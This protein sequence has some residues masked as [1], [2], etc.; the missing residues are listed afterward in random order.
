MDPQE[1][2]P[3]RARPQLF[4][5]PDSSKQP[6]FRESILATIDGAAVSPVAT[7]RLL[8]TRTKVAVGLVLCVGGAMLAAY[9]NSKVVAPTVVAT[10]TAEVPKQR[11]RE[12]PLLEGRANIIDSTP[13]PVSRKS[14]AGPQPSG[15]DDPVTGLNPDPPPDSVV[16]V[17]KTDDPR[18][19]QKKVPVRPAR[20]VA[21]AAAA[22]KQSPTRKPDRRDPDVEVVA[23]MLPYLST[24]TG[25]ESP[26][27][28]RR[29]GGLSGN[30][31]NVC[32]AK[33]CN[34]REGAD[35]ACPSGGLH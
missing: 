6:E 17:T 1:H 32:R 13:V 27:L 23:A 19:L 24:P 21:K 29:C 16:S 31:A 9:R 11:V 15:S 7:P 10:A 4:S 3:R 22:K 30:A 25:P 28:D 14:E 35:P 5:G 20:E 34:G 12:N 26:G 8:S 2:R 33:F 18:Q